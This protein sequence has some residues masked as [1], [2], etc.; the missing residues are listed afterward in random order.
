MYTFLM[1]NLG[2][3]WLILLFLLCFVCVH[4]IKLAKIGFD[5]TQGK[6]QLKEPKQKNNPDAEKASG[7]QPVYYVVSRKRYHGKNMR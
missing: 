2:F 1:E 6:T 5:Y 4:L 3:L 7:K